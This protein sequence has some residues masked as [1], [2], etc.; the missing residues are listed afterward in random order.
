MYLKGRAKLRCMASIPRMA[1]PVHI[2]LNETL[3]EVNQSLEKHGVGPVS[4]LSRLGLLGPGLIAVHMVHAKPEEIDLLA[5]QGCH[6]VHCPTSNLKLASG[7][8]P[9]LEMMEAGVNVALGTDG[10]A[11]NNRSDMLSELR[12]AALLAKGKSGIAEALPASQALRMA[13]LG[14]AAAMGMDHEIGSFAMGKRADM[15]AIELSGAEIAPVYDPISHIVY[16]TGREHVSHVWV[17][18]EI[19]LEEGRLTGLDEA[20]LVAKAA[21]WKDKI[22]QGKLS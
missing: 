15:I 13:T 3:D 7:F 18:G 6:V 19:R 12:L 5:E 16:C 4:R 1:G 10:A 2:H 21:W 14:G 8:A 20:G 9:V 22:A 17:D 11:S